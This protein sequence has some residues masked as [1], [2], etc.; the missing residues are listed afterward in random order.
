MK[1]FKKFLL[2]WAVYTTAIT[3]IFYLFV[4]LSGLTDSV[5]SMAKYFTILLFGAI[6]SASALVFDTR[7]NPIIKYLVN[8]G[9][10]LFAFCTVFLSSAG[11]TDNRVARAFAAVFIFSLFYLLALMLK[12][13]YSVIFKKAKKRGAKK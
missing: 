7:L 9:V 13:L 8:Y 10:L 12:Y 1:A 2:G 5:M 4:L 6:I 11:A 3:T